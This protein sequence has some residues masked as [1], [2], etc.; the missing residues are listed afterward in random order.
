MLSESIFNVPVETFTFPSQL[1]FLFRFTFPPETFSVAL[2]LI[3]TVVFA[4]IV[5][6]ETLISETVVPSPIFRIPPVIL[7]EEV[8]MS[9][10][11]SVTVVVP[12]V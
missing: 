3:L 2:S 4:P 8:F 1:P 7:S 12:F 5:P 10:P 11:V 6:C 9:K